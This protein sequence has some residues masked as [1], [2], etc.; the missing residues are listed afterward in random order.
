MRLRRWV[1]KRWKSPPFADKVI[2]YERAG[3]ERWWSTAGKATRSERG[4]S[5]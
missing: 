5:R 4:S 1:L 3:F 2:V